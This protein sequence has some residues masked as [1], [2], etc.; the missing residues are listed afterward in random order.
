MKIVIV[1]DDKQAALDLKDRLLRN[2]KI[3]VA[4]VALNGLE[5]LS[6]VNKHRPDVLFLDVQLPDISG[7]D[8]LD[9]IDDFTD[10]ECRVV[11]FTAYDKFILP[12]FRKKAFDVLLKPI[13]NKD[14]ALIMARLE[15]AGTDFISPAYKGVTI[16]EN[17]M[18]IRNQ[19]EEK[20]LLY[21][22]S[23]DFKLVDK[24]DIGVFQYN[25]ISR[26]WEVV[27][28]GVPTPIRLKRNVNSDS[29]AGLDTQFVQINQ[30]YII[31]M[32]YLIEVVDHVCHFYPPFDNI[33]Y[34]KVGRFFRK[35]FIER[36][37]SL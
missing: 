36:F 9:R 30:K 2:Y 14:L 23:T 22:N 19:K 32:D 29:L 21:T 15:E 20:Y 18:T 25:H 37:C 1:D 11:M 26:S 6:L 10:G 35:K 28:A 31:N 12:A 4:G 24:R 3:E 5:G 8:F 7:L 13:D 34:V 16:D 33:D 27:V 17:G